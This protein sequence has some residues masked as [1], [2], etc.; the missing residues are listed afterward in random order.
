MKRKT[1][2]LLIVLSGTAIVLFAF[3][4][5]IYSP[6]RVHHCLP[7]VGENTTLTCSTYFFSTYES[8]SC[9]VLG[10]G[11]GHDNVTAGF[12]DWSYYVGCPSKTVYLP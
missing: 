5:I 7:P 10:I 6:L 11:V 1:V 12:G 2:M 4:P 9:A 8:P 3:V